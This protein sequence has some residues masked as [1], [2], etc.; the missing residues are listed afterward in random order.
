[1]RDIAELEQAMEAPSA[2]PDGPLG[3][4]WIRVQL[5]LTQS[6]RSVLHEFIRHRFA[7]TLEL[8]ASNSAAP[9]NLKQHLAMLNKR[10]AESTHSG[11]DL[12]MQALL[13]DVDL[14]T[15]Q[16]QAETRAIANG[17]IE[18]IAAQPGVL[19]A[20]YESLWQAA[21]QAASSSN[22][23]R[24]E[25]LHEAI[26]I[27]AELS[28]G[29]DAIPNP[30]V[31]L[32]YGWAQVGSGQSGDGA[33]MRGVLQGVREP[34]FEARLCAELLAVSKAQAERWDEA[35][36]AVG[37][38]MAAGAD[39]ELLAL[40]GAVAL[41]AGKRNEAEASLREAFAT[42]PVLVLDWLAHEAEPHS[43]GLVL[44]WAEEAARTGAD[45]A[46]GQFA[47][48]AAR[49]RAAE[50]QSGLTLISGEEGLPEL[51]GA[52]IVTLLAAQAR[53]EAAVSRLDDEAQRALHQAKL[54]AKTSRKRV[55]AELD[56]LQRNRNGAIEASAAEKAAL[57]QQAREQWTKAIAGQG[58]L[59][60]GCT[61]SVGAGCGGLVLYAI[62]AVVLGATGTKAG[63]DT[64][65]G[66]VAM[67][68]IGS[69]L[70]FGAGSQVAYGMKRAAWEADLNRRLDEARKRH[71]A[72]LEE[73]N[74][75][76]RTTGPDLEKKLGEFTER[77]RTLDA[78]HW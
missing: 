7:G 54:E 62:L 75:Q 63:L 57:E 73:A 43:V 67:I 29:V 41:R 31:W 16:V 12:E 15:A 74:R 60:R 77:L 47:D 17:A 20:R 6:D 45:I 10:L 3:R 37:R 72:I 59:G 32:L 1:M 39:P 11:G 22:Q 8:I 35:T 44:G 33:W 34:G 2:L 36:Q 42:R 70:L 13:D 65:I 50:V 52:D 68:L 27:G 23:D 5:L 76:F 18:A 14:R 61:L 25:P 56:V 38:A 46:W 78:V 48:Q 66:L 49:I 19:R 26:L 4:A 24:T 51:G 53:A 55:Q 69:S 21:T 71:D 30:F 58:A 9:P 40:A 64:P 28:D